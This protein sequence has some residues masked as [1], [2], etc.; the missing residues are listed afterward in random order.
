M[1]EHSSKQA[2]KQASTEKSNYKAI[3]FARSH[4]SHQTGYTTIV[5]NKDGSIRGLR[6]SRNGNCV[7]IGSRQPAKSPSSN[8]SS[9]DPGE[10]EKQVD[11]EELGSESSSQ[12][13]E[14]EGEGETRTE[15]G[16]ENTVQSVRFTEDTDFTTKR[17]YT[18]NKKGGRR[19]GGSSKTYQGSMKTLNY[20]SGYSRR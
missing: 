15:E 14:G 17:T 16:K 13:H 8:L 12:E 11:V 20:L 6:R 3:G 19:R 2:S 4:G 1:S 18:R 10:E 9:G 5:R 7:T